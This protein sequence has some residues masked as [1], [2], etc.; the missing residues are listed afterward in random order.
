MSAAIVHSA[1]QWVAHFGDHR[2]R[3]AVTIGNFD[4]VHLGHQEI[5]RKL[6]DRALLEDLM[7]AVL[8]F[9]P[10]PARLLRPSEAPALLETLEQ[11]LAAIG[12]LGIDVVFVARFDA[13]L[14]NL[15]PEEFVRQYLVETMR[16]QAVLIGGNFRFG[17]RQAG[18]ARLLTELGREGDFEIEIV[19]PM[20]SGGTVVSSTAIRNA[21][22]EGKVDEARH[23]LGRAFTLSGEIQTGTG[24]GR[25]LVVPTLNL[26]TD[27]ELLP[28]AGVYATEAVVKGKTYR[29][30]T[31]IGVRP[32]FDG[33][34]TTIESHL[35]DFHETLNSGP[36]E[37][38]FGMRLR[39]ERKFASPAEL[40]EQVIRDI[41]TARQYFEARH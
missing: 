7:S 30:A 9:H 26:A 10:H 2:K 35:L 33:A 36:L 1:D 15:A 4:G 12:A 34:H 32:T 39:E 17:H 21:L 31:N 18:D 37:L 3:T 24:Q 19:P 38:R 41:E 25:Q 13:A 27:Q 8:T 22:R 16:S 29:A 40:R 28:K 5:L 20:T 23:Q 6:R 11:R 14:A